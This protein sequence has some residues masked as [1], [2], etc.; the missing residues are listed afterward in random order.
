MIATALKREDTLVMPS[1]GAPPI[2]GPAQ[3][4]G[5]EVLGPCQVRVAL[6]GHTHF[7]M[8]TKLSEAAVRAHG[9][10]S[11]YTDV[12]DRWIGE[13]SFNT[14]TKAGTFIAI[15]GNVPDEEVRTN[16]GKCASLP[17]LALA[18]AAYFL[19]TGQDLFAGNVGCAKENELCF[20]TFGLDI[21]VAGG[22]PRRSW[23]ASRYLQD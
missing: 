9:R 10:E 20:Y 7:D 21:A 3:E 14:A 16:R 23:V 15:N 6:D 4:Y 17:D 8:L 18:H 11:V 5:I 2:I 1:T 12:L 19:A 13:A 22:G